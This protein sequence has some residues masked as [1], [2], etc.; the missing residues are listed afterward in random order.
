MKKII[1]KLQRF[2]KSNI[3]SVPALFF[4]CVM[5][6]ACGSSK[7]DPALEQYRTD[8]TNFSN[9]VASLSQAI[10]SIDPSSPDAPAAFLNELDQM[11]TAFR[12]MSNL[13]VPADYSEAGI[14]AYEAAAYMNDAVSLYHEAY[15]ENGYN[16][17]Y[18]EQAQTQYQSAMDRVA[19]IGQ[20]FMEH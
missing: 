3:L 19:S 11:N 16:E 1:C 14:M 7:P 9:T 4:L 20:Y 12:N 17:S 8:M 15:G 5:L 6:S 13:T 18:A 2:V 10:N